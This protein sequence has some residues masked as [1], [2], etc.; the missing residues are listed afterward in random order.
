MS[1]VLHDLKILFFFNSSLFFKP[2]VVKPGS[3][4]KFPALALALLSLPNRSSGHG[5][6]YLIAARSHTATSEKQRGDRH[7]WLEVRASSWQM[8]TSTAVGEARL[9]SLEYLSDCRRA[10]L[11][12][13]QGGL[14]FFPPFRWG[15]SRN[16]IQLF[17]GK[18]QLS[19]LAVAA[20]PE[21]LPWQPG[22]IALPLLLR[23]KSRDL[24][25]Q[26]PPLII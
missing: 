12:A 11:P 24:Q 14:G 10:D 8:A 2:L 1:V 15:G 9:S 19:T 5:A 6:D 26:P 21:L 20:L 3:T 22:Y 16:L 18:E 25:L 13:K 4:R 23:T 7:R 17:A